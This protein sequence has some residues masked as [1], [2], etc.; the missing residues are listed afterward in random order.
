MDQDVQLSTAEML[1]EE[2]KYAPTS[3]FT[4]DGIVPITE[5]PASPTPIMVALMD[6]ALQY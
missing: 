5:K 4:A 3:V 6:D 1:E 2:L